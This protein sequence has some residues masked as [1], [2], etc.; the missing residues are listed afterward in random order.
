MRLLWNGVAGSPYYTNLYFAGLLQ[1]DVDAANVPV[2]TFI[3]G[4][5]SAIHDSLTV[6]IDPDVPVID[7]GTG[8]I[9]DY[10]NAAQDPIDQPTADGDM[11]PPGNQALITWRTGTVIGGRRILGR[12][13]LP[14]FTEP[15]STN[16]KPVQTLV[17]QL[18]G[19][20]RGLV[21]SESAQLVIWSRSNS[22][23]AVVNG[24]S[25]SDQWSSLRTRRFQ[26]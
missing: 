9:V 8:D 13:F 25:C 19:A 16:G 14:G 4:I 6:S 3:T 10:L 24:A 26:N 23:S 2:R 11:L 12:T 20:A 1:S 17:D 18:G 21:D 22:D 7:P 15:D 5:R